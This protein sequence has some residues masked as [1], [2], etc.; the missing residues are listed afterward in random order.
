MYSYEII[1]Q[2]EPWRKKRTSPPWIDYPMRM[3][4]L[5]SSNGITPVVVF[6]GVSSPA[7]GPT[8]IRRG[9]ALL[10]PVG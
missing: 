6:D 7:K 9:C 1:T 4:S 2:T 5:L 10:C 8:G 3:I